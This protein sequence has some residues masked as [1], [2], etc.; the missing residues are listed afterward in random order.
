MKELK[1]Q[2]EVLLDNFEPN[3]KISKLIKENLKKYYTTLPK[4]FAQTTGK[5]FLVKHTRKIDTIIKLVYRIATRE[6]FDCYYPAKNY[7]PLTIVALGSYGREQLSPKSDIDIMFI[8]KNIPAYNILPLIEKMYYLL[9]D[10]GLKLGHRVDEIDELEDVANSD[11]TIKT[12]ILESR[13]IDGSKPLWFDTEN[14][15]NRIRHNNQKK[16]ILAKIEE[17]RKNRAKYPLMMESN[18]KE[19]VGGFRDANLI[20]WIGK[21][22][23]NAP[24]IKD[25]PKKIVDEKDYTEFRVALEFLFKVRSALHL[26]VKKKTDYLRLND[27]PQVASLLGYKSNKAHMTFAKRVNKSLRTIWL[28]SRIWLDAL[29]SKH[30]SI[31]KE[32]LKPEKNY[33]SAEELLSFLISNANRPYRSHP[34]LNLQLLHTTKEIDNRVFLSLI[35]KIFKAKYTSSILTALSEANRL[36]QYIQPIKKVEA[37]PQFDG[38]HKFTVD[39]HLIR[40]VESLEN[41]ENS[42]LKKIYDDLDE[43]KKMILKFAIFLHDIG[44]GREMDHHILGAKLFRVYTKKLGLN[45]ESI[46]LGTKL[47][48]HHN[49]LSQVAQ[50]EDIYN[51]KVVA[52]FTGLFPSKIELDMIL[53]LTYADT[54]GVGNNIYN[55]FTARLFNRLYQNSL[56]Y[57][58]HNNFIDEM[59]KRVQRLDALRR[60]I[61]FK[62]LPNIIRK[63]I[64]NIESNL[65]FIRYTTSRIIEIAKRAYEIDTFAYEVTNRKFLTIEI[66]KKTPIDL[67]YL[68]SKLVNFNL[69][70]MDVVKLFDDKKYFK[71][72]FNQKTNKDAIED[73]KLI[74]QNAFLKQKRIDLPKPDI[75]KEDISIDCKHSIEYASIKLNTKNQKGLLAYIM[76]IFEKLEIDIVSSKI[77]THKGIA[78]DIFLI[79]KNRNF[80]Q[81]LDYIIEKITQ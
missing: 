22:L 25:L 28:Y 36:G 1:A 14:R 4:T 9:I 31:Y 62:K 56:E 18:L 46:K 71:I 20:Y 26:C 37:L 49:K 75:K 52:N 63:K 30:V 64:L 19:G 3:F 43:D 79:E 13:F 16:F 76:N 17:R 15:I 21:L 66:I 23:Y 40:C 34:K 73:I 6:M 51:P 68:L 38:Y 44:K 45:Q 8:Y 58:Q 12:A 5:D 70:N 10:A 65:P 27:L 72:D 24:R 7:I 53:L 55:E 35:V 81:K 48:L 59:T 77:Y 67:G 69:V 42:K 11:I 39:T 74:I 54:N 41:L 60:S 47:I 80:C 78:N 33:K 32:Y 50:K 61:M 29:A 2:I 57:L